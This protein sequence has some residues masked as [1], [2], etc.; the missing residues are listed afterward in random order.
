MAG[1]YYGVGVRHRDNIDTALD[2]IDYNRDGQANITQLGG[3][4]EAIIKEYAELSAKFP[5]FV[6]VA[7]K[8]A[9]D[10]NSSKIEFVPFVIFK[11]YY[12]SFVSRGQMVIEDVWCDRFAK[13]EDCWSVASGAQFFAA[14][15]GLNAPKNVFNTALHKYVL[16]N[17]ML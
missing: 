14:N 1:D 7:L 9:N 6:G 10:G 17:K 3:I 2:R 16:K 12:E 11:R 4:S 8:R 13:P 15:G 5:G